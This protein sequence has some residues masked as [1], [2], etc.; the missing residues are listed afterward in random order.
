MFVPQALLQ[1]FLRCAPNVGAV[2]MSALV[3]YESGGNPY[4]VG[5]NTTRRSYAPAGRAAAEA[6]AVR[7]LRAGHRIDVGY[8]QIDSDNFA[9]LGLD[10]AVAFEPCVNVAAG[11]RILTEAYAGAGRR[12]G[13]GQAALVHALSAYNSGGYWSALPYAHGVYAQAAALRFEASS[14]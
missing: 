6:L 7:L 11:A 8:A 5:D 3:A 1:L 9:R 14:R 10:P 2:T 4:A 12:F 13:P